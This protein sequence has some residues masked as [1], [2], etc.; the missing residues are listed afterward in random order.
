MY[1]VWS[2]NVHIERGG[3]GLLGAQFLWIINGTLFI[4][5]TK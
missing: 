4:F 5:N 2:D 1:N 3:G